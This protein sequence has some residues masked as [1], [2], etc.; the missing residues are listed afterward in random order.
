MKIRLD[1]DIELFYTIDDF[2]DPWTKSDTVV[3][4]HGMAKSH[5]MWFGWV[6]IIARHYR[7]IRFDMRGMGLSDVSGLEHS[8]TLDTFTADLKEFADKCDVAIHATAE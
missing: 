6:P 3:M 4:H 1:D 2:T 8:Y 7:V 5:K